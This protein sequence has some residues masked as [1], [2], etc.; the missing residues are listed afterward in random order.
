MTTG[1]LLRYRVTALGRRMAGPRTASGALVA[2][3]AVAAMLATTWAVWG[4]AVADLSAGAD[5]LAL[6]IADRVFW[7]SAL[8]AL[9]FA[10]TSFEVIFRA[11]D[12]AF[13]A[14]LPVDGRARWMDLQL[15]AYTLHLLLLLP[16]VTYATTVLNAGHP[17]AASRI[18]AVSAT[19]YIVGIA[20]CSWLHLMAGR[21]MLRVATPLS[22]SLAGAAIDD[23]AALILYA[24][25]AGLGL[26]LILIVFLDLLAS[27]TLQVAGQPA[28]LLTTAV[29]LWISAA[30]MVRRAALEARGCLTLVISRFQEV[31]TPLPYRDDGIPEETPGEGL[32]DRLS[33]TT[34]AL[35][36]RDL[37]QLRRRHRLDRILLWVFAALALRAGLTSAGTDGTLV[38]ELL[39]L[40]V[41]FVGLFWTNAFR[42]QGQEL[43]SP[44]MQRTLPLRRAPQWTAG[45][46]VDLTTPGWALLWAT[47]AALLAQQWMHSAVVL[48]VGVTIAIT[49]GLLSRI[50]ARW[51]DGYSAAAA[52]AW[53][54]S[55]IILIAL[56]P[57]GTP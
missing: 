19:S 38:R 56:A 12:G 39:T 32:A 40:Y 6:R 1:R 29:L 11:P 27:R 46:F 22:R 17:F 21:T 23:D 15:R 50:I 52:I 3:L 28:I 30:W 26:T 41:A 10:Y 18:L 5:H 49:S 37:L 9:V 13:I 48:G 47:A 35:F 42:L 16:A 44:W 45:L 57:G 55:I 53:R 31:D 36:L 43:G 7:L 14:L 54:A 34:A 25:A 24:P 33:R 2:L 8:P 20:L 51:M 4:W